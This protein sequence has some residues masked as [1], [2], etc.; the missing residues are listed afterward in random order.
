MTPAPTP[1][2]IIWITTDHLR[3]DCIGAN[4]NEAIRTPNLDRLA[5]NGVSLD[6][7]YVQNPLCMPSRASFMTGQYPCR[8]GVA[9]NGPALPEDRGPTC[10][11]VFKSAG[12]HTAQIGK[13]HFEPHD[14]MDLDPAGRCR[15]GFDFMAVSEEPGCYE[16]AYTRWLR[17][18]HPEYAAT[19]RVPRPRERM[20]RSDPGDGWTVDAPA[21]VSHA[22]FVADQ[23]MHYLRYG[24]PSFIHSGIYAPHPPFNPPAGV[25]ALYE[26]ADLPAPH[27]EE[28]EQDDKPEPLKSMLM[29]RHSMSEEH[30]RRHRRFFYSMVTMLDSQVGRI[31]D[32][33]EERGEL[34]DT[35]ILFM[36][37][38][39]DM[40]GDHRM[41]SK[42]PSFY[43]EVMHVPAILHW[44]G[45]LVGGRRLTAP[46]EAVD[47]L[48]TLCELCGL[49]VPWQMQG[50]SVAA[51]LRGATEGARRDVLAMHGGPGRQLYLMLRSEEFKYIRYAEGAEVLYHLVE[52]P[53]EHRNCAG[54]GRFKEALHTMR[55][56]ALERTLQAASPG[57]PAHRPF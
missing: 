57:V 46:V 6:Q 55:E 7:C 48:P 21:S 47:L 3:Y 40:D 36:S 34:E 44:P 43:D 33:L 12:Y 18:E 20:R 38:H 42:Q 1:R 32:A 31:V 56:R 8:T 11:E 10:A 2:N 35:L 41:L 4:G 27:W 52:D 16:D 37:D 13:L 15:Y 53:G 30:M 45:G 51:Q 25:F 39:G 19:M 17:T 22:G 23:T 9:S 49:R 14:E 50:R 24:W 26:H 54:D 29:Q 5:A 28:G